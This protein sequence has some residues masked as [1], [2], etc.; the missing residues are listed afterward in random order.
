MDDKE[1]EELEELR[2]IVAGVDKTVKKFA[3]K[4]LKDAPRGAIPIESFFELLMLKARKIGRE[5]AFED[6]VEKAVQDKITYLSTSYIGKHIRDMVYLPILIRRA[7]LDSQKYRGYCLRGGVT[8]TPA[9][10]T[11]EIAY[12]TIRAQTLNH[13][14]KTIADIATCKAD[15]M[16]EY[17]AAKFYKEDV[18]AGFR[19][20]A[21]VSETEHKGDEN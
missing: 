10:L 6:L 13:F 19:V 11:I 21:K 2:Q 9:S 18:V 4:Y 12:E 14:S 5:K 7:G 16:E 20:F 3:K 15:L 8:K 17:D 1:R